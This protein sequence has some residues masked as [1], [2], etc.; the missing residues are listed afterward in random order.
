MKKDKKDAEYGEL[1]IDCPYCNK[2]LKV[3]LQTTKIPPHTHPD[4]PSTKCPGSGRTISES[5]TAT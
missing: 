3:T 2:E 1:T 4:S 5:W